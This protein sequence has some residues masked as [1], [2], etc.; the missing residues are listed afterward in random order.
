MIHVLGI[1]PG[2]ISGWALVVKEGHCRARV[3]A[4]GRTG[5][6]TKP[7][8][9]QSDGM[10]A[11]RV[12]REIGP[13]VG[14]Q[15]WP[16]WLAIEGQFIP[17]EGGVHDKQRSHAIDALETARHAGGWL[18]VAQRYGLP[19]YRHKGQPTIPPGVWRRGIYGRAAPR[20]AE[21][22]KRVAIEV[23]ARVYETKILRTHH[24]TAEAIL[25]AAYAADELYIRP[26]TAAKEG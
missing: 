6:R 5:R 1:D 4:H 13:V 21:Q 17:R 16:P 14:E 7:G 15:H 18:Y 23:A 22:A 11:Y 2:A 20:R 12:L 9:I 25:I 10:A 3:L 26:Q 8:M 24:H 19:V